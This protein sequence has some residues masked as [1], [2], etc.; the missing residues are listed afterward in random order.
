MTEAE[1]VAYLESQA[2]YRTVR[3]LGGGHYHM[4]TKWRCPT[5]YAKY[6]EECVLTVQ[7]NGMVV[8]YITLRYVLAGEVMDVRNSHAEPFEPFL[9]TSYPGSI[10][11]DSV[12]G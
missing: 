8:S 5:S 10:T 12:F 1:V 4:T 9:I 7:P 2:Y 3:P 11:W 6:L